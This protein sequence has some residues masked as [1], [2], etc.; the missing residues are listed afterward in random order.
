[1]GLVFRGARPPL[2]VHLSPAGKQPTTAVLAGT[3]E[4]I[5]TCRPLYL[6]ISNTFRGSFLCGFSGRQPASM[7]FIALSETW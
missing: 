6:S 4:Q 1:V 7:P 2:L 5:R 3:V